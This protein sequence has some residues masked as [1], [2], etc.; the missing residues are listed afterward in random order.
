MRALPPLA[1]ALAIS[2]IATSVVADELHYNQISLR[3]E[4]SRDIPADL[5]QVTLYTEQ[6][7]KDP[8]KLAQQIT[9]ALN[10]AIK[11]ARAVD[12]VEI[13]LGSRSSYPVYD[14]KNNSRTLQAWRERA[15][16]QLESQNFAAL[17]Q[18]TGKLLG[19]LQ[20]GSMSF[21]IS[22]ASRQTN[23]QELLDEAIKAFQ[24][25]AQQVAKS[26]GG[27]DY[28]LVHLNLGGS[29]YPPPMPMHRGKMA[30][31]AMDSAEA[32]PEIEAGKQRVSVSAEGTI[33]VQ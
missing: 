29:G 15:E 28:K 24:Q 8:A 22:E 11:T 12:G 14:H 1:S 20:M 25:R 27:Q 9:E 32:T 30:M 10:A 2:L 18:L 21:S 3:A 4:A 33:Q 17:S 13:T 26:L 6:Q 31:M 5:M 7:D 19:Q 16:V 23:E